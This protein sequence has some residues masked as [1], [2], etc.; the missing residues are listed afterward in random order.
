MRKIFVLCPGQADRDGELDSVGL[1]QAADMA[2]RVRGIAGTTPQLRMFA[3]GGVACQESATIIS[4][5]LDLGGVVM[6]SPC[7]R[8]QDFPA[9]IRQIL[10]FLE[11]QGREMAYLVVVLPP[12]DAFVLAEELSLKFE[13]GVS[14]P[15]DIGPEKGFVVDAEGKTAYPV[16]LPAAA[17]A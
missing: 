10:E 1:G 9:R 14:A 15:D 17:S 3:G 11:S 4:D 5:T 6:V 2:R 13:T 12:D 7:L 8:H 16:T